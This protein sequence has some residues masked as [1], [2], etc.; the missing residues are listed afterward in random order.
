MK[1]IIAKFKSNCAETGQV[2]KKGDT[3]FYNYTTRKCY[4]LNSP[5]AIAEQAEASEESN[6]IGSYVQAEQEAYFDNFCQANNI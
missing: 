6:S 4:A 3:M 2:I 5:T 1:R